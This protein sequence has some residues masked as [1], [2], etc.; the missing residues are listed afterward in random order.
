MVSPY[1]KKPEGRTAGAGLLPSNASY[2]LPIVYYSQPDLT[3]V[4]GVVPVVPHVVT[5]KGHVV[6]NRD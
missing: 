3:N 6:G 2:Q 4:T 5:S 1:S